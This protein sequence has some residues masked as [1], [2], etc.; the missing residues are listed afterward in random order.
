MDM[1]GARAAVVNYR[2]ETPL[3]GLPKQMEIYRHFRKRG[4]SVGIEGQNALVLDNFWYRQRLYASHAGNEF[5]FVGMSILTNPPDHLS[6]D[7]FCLVMHNAFF[8]CTISG[9]VC[10]MET[11][12]RERERTAEMGRINH[13]ANEALTVVG[14]PW[15]RQTECGTSWSSGRGAALFIWHP[16]RRL[17]LTLPPGWQI[18]KVLTLDGTH[19]GFTATEATDL[20]HKSVVIVH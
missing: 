1:G 11:V 16:T 9:Y 5:A 4:V 12:P 10:D 3:P 7:Y 20:P 6:M 18:R 17:R 2:S 13:L 8:Q 15:V 14:R 19:R